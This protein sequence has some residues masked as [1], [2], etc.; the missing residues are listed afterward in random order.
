MRI[1]DPLLSLSA[2]QIWIG[3]MADN[4]PRANQCDLHHQIIKMLGMIS[5]QRGHLRTALDLEHAYGVSLLN[6]FV[7]IRLVLREMR[8]INFFFV[9]MANQINRIFEHS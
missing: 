5:R 8:K 4:R 9:M 2:L 7:N 6:Y 1:S 3:H